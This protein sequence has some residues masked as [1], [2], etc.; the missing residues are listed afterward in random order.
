MRRRNREPEPVPSR[1][2]MAPLVDDAGEPML[3]GG[4]SFS[5]GGV[6]D[7]MNAGLSGEMATL[8]ARADHRDDVIAEREREAA[9]IER[10]LWA[11]SS[12]FAGRGPVG[13]GDLLS[14]VCAG[15]DRQDRLEERRRAT[16]LEADG[17]EAASRWETSSRMSV[18]DRVERDRRE[19]Q[20][21]PATVG[22]VDRLTAEISH[23]KALINARR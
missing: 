20:A 16:A 3:S 13:H 12:T 7:Y 2:V 19:R 15:M 23:I 9:L 17:R 5:A 11:R 1:V 21:Q 6:A 18:T 14:S 4:A 22:E 10:E 8:R